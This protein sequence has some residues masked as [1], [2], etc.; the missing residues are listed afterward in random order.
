MSPRP[1]VE[2]PPH[3]EPAFITFGFEECLD[4]FF[5]FG[6]FAI[7]HEANIFPEQLYRCLIYQ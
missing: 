5:A 2:I 4:S 7:A 1:T 6:L 3:I